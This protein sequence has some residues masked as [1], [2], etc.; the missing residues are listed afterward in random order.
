[1]DRSSGAGG[2]VADERDDLD[3]GMRRADAH[4]FAMLRGF[5]GPKRL[6]EQVCRIGR[7]VDVAES[8]GAVG[9]VVARATRSK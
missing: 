1:M 4:G 5:G 3:V 8:G 6:G 9:M 2:G 7:G